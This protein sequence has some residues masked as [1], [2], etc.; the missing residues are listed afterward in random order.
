MYFSTIGGDQRLK[1]CTGYGVKGLRTTDAEEAFLLIREGIDAHAGVFVSGPEVGLCYGYSDSDRVEDREI[2]G[3][4]NWGPAFHGTYSWARFSKHV[5]AF[6][7]AEG[8]S[9]VHHES[10]PESVE[11]I[12]EMIATTVIDWQNKHSATNFGMKH[13]FR[14]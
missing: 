12:F 10:K 2:Y 7:D 6:G 11:H 9:F 5:E 13:S 14:N 1:R 8:F 3:I 4:S